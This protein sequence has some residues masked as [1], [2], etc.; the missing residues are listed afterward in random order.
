MKYPACFYRVSVK[1]AVVVGD[2]LLLVRED[3]DDWELPGGGMEHHEGLMEALSR[4]IQEELGVA[5][6]EVDESR[7]QPWVMYDEEDE[8]PLLH[9]VY[10]VTLAQVP[11]PGR[12]ANVVMDYF[13]ADQLDELKIVTWSTKYRQNLKD[14]LL[15]TTQ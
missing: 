10:P 5:I 8:R 13:V 1:A 9:I 7:L 12:H 15:T 3:G 4:E 14:F 11:K 6:T 2:K